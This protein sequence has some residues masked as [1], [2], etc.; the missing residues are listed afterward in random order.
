EIVLS[1]MERAERLG[2]TREDYVWIF[3][4]PAMK[5]AASRDTIKKTYPVGSFVIGFDS[6]ASQVKEL[7]NQVSK[8]WYS[9]L[10]MMAVSKEF[11]SVDF[12]THFSCDVRSHATNQSARSLYWKYGEHLYK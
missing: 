5:Q 1:V 4:L 9:A 3:T 12:Q 10:K 6:Y 2:L 11:E 8:M 7:H